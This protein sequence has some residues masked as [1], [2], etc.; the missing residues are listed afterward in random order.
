MVA[1]G[2]LLACESL[3]ATAT[4]AQI[5]VRRGLRAYFGGGGGLSLMEV[6]EAVKTA[7]EYVGALF[8]EEL[9]EDLGLEEV[10]YD[11]V[12]QVWEITI[13][14]SRPWNRRGLANLTHP[15]RSYKKISIRQSD[16]EVRSVVHRELTNVN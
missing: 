9:I 14:F 1:V 4:V 8:T 11:E 13:G 5:D 15:R 16:G 6:K 10:T 3:G 2:P 7:K 12:S